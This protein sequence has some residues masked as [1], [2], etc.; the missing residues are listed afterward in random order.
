MV[1]PANFSVSRDPPPWCV[2][3]RGDGDRSH[4]LKLNYSTI[5]YDTRMTASQTL[6]TTHD[7]HRERADVANHI[8][9]QRTPLQMSHEASSILDF[10]RPGDVLIAVKLDLS[11]GTRATFSNSCTNW[12]RKA[13]APGC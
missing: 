10:I 1:P 4:S 8:N 12:K 7:G 3:G 5:L 9:A 2:W 13:Q 11:G 6:G